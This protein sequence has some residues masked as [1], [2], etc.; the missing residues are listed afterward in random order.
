MAPPETRACPS[1]TLLRLR[2][3]LLDRADQKVDVVVE[4]FE[5]IRDLLHAANRRRHHQHL[6]ACRAANGLRRLQVEVWFDEQK[7]DV[8]SFHFVYQVEGVL[9]RRRNTGGGLDITDYLDAESF[10]KIRKRTMVRNSFRPFV[11]RHHL[12][13]PF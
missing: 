9:W 11:R 13:P 7:L 6:C 8:L 3:G 2:S 5:V 12:E 10:G 1:R 4:Q